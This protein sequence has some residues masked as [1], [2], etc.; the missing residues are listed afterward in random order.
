[1]RLIE[2]G[3]HSDDARGFA[4]ALGI[5]ERD[6]LALARFADQQHAARTEGQ[7]AGALDIVGEHRDVETRGQ[8]EL[9][10]IEG[11]LFGVGQRDDADRQQHE[12]KCE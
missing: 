7:H 1:M 2:S 11:S 5:G 12:R 8:L 6:H 10:E 4:G 3:E 9:L